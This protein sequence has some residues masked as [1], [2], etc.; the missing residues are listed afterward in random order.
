MN[1]I[2]CSNCGKLIASD[3]NFCTFC[4][5]PTRGKG[6]SAFR[7][8]DPIVTD[9]VAIEQ[10]VNRA[11]NDIPQQSL[12]DEPFDYKSLLMPKQHLGNDAIMYFF[13]NFIGKSIVLLGLM[14]VGMVFMPLIFVPATIFYLVIVFI[15]ALIVH[16]NFVF[17]IDES[18]LIIEKGVLHKYS[19]TVPFEQVQNVN[20][21]R[22][23]MDRFLGFSKV[24]IE[25]AGGSAV[26]TPNGAPPKAEAYIPAIHMDKAKKIHD[27]LL[28]GADG[29]IDGK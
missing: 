12:Q 19:V 7:A 24:S 6:A 9:T 23:L 5:V 28:D 10:M 21:E 26:P 2:Y 15:T 3:S 17:E 1:Q 16:N 13:V 18:G 25:T 8:N 29:V 27:L 11:N 22:S 20:I 4:G 14:I